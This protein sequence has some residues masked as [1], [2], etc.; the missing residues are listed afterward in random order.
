MEASAGAHIRSNVCPRETLL[1]LFL[2]G[3]EEAKPLP[4]HTVTGAKEDFKKKG[5]GGKEKN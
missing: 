1:H 2:P 3:N 4:A 5:G